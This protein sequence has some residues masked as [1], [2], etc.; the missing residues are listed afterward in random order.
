MNF[1]VGQIVYLLSR[2]DTSAYPAQ[3]I[4][5]IKRKTIERE[6]ISYIIKLPNKDNSEV[7]LEEI[8]ADVFTSISDL[9]S[10]M[11]ENAHNQIKIFL[12]KTR[13]LESAFNPICQ[14]E[15]VEIPNDSNKVEIDLGDGLKGKIDISELP[16]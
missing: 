13:S 7:L 8:N 5:E 4:E 10:K 11:I 9:E 1:E 15:R 14:E 16:A 6:I 2:K 12:D 3:V